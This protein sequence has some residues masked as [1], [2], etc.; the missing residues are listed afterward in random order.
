MLSFGKKIATVL[1]LG[2]GVYGCSSREL[3]RRG[4]AEN[5][6]PQIHEVQEK[7]PTVTC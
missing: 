7:N 1:L 4:E 5:K 2:K 6:P 3:A